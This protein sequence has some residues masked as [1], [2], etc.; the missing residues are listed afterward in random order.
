MTVIAAIRTPTSILIGGDSAETN[1]AGSIMLLAE[2]K[3]F[4]KGEYLFGFAGTGCLEN[5][6]KNQFSPP[7][8]PTGNSWEQFMDTSFVPGLKAALGDDSYLMS[9]A[10]VLIGTR[11]GGIYTLDGSWRMSQSRERYAAIGSG[12]SYA[13]GSFH[14]TGGNPRQRLLKALR[15]AAHFNAYVRPPF[16]ILELPEEGPLEEQFWDN[17]ENIP[18][19]S[20][21]FAVDPDDRG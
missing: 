14:S 13:L 17:T 3:V 15:A 7:C 4:R 2:P 8:R 9:G 1:R 6:A 18:D 10:Q 11:G 19:F 5:I 21:I 16:T 20:T 12:T